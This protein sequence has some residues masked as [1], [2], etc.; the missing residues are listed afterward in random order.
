MD[1]E[2]ALELH[3]RVW[4]DTIDLS[5]FVAVFYKFGLD[6]ESF[7]TRKYFTQGLIKFLYMKLKI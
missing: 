5:Y 4:Y 7:Y 2:Y 1:H 3:F 6:T